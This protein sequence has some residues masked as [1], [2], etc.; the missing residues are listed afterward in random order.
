M[1]SVNFTVGCESTQWGQIVGVIG[2][3]CHWA[4]H[5]ATPLSTTASAFPEWT[6]SVVLPGFIVA[7]SEVEY[8]YVILANGTVVRWE[9]GDNRS[10]RAPEAGGSINVDGG[11]FSRERLNKPRRQRNGLKD[12]R[13]QVR[14]IPTESGYRLGDPPSLAVAAPPVALE[15]LQPL[16]RALVKV[17]G[18]QSS[19]RQRLQFIRSVI[20]PS[21]D[22]DGDTT[23][24]ADIGPIAGDAGSLAVIAAYLSF[25]STGQLRCE[26]DGGHH[27]PNRHAEAAQAIDAALT[28]A[29]AD[30]YSPFVARRIYPL[31]PSYAPQ[32]T[33][34]TPLTRIRDIAHR[35]DIP[36]DLKQEIKHTLQNKLH[37]CAGPEDLVTCARL[38]ERV[39]HGGYSDA[40]VHELRRFHAELKQFFN[41]EGLDDRLQHLIGVDGCQ[42]GAA[43]MLRVKQANAKPRDQLSALTDLR[44]TL[45]GQMGAAKADDER[46]ATR[47]ADI[48]LE[49]YAFPLLAALAGDAENIDYGCKDLAAHLVN[50]LAPVLALAFDNIGLSG[51]RPAEADA[52]AAEL[53]A[54]QLMGASRV[55]AL[56]ARAAVARAQRFAGAFASAVGDLFGPRVVAL[57]AAL[58]VESRA[59]AVF[60]ESEVRAN[61]AFQA[62]R[63]ADAA[64]SIARSVLGLPAWDPLCAGRRTGVPLYVENLEDVVFD[65]GAK[66]TIVIARNANGEEDIPSQVVAVILGR[67]MPHLSHLAL[68]AR[69][70]NVVFVCAEERGEFQ[71]VWDAPRPTVGLISVTVAD[72]LRQFEACKPPVKKAA[73]SSNTTTRSKVAIMGATEAATGGTKSTVTDVEMEPLPSSDSTDVGADV[74]STTGAEKKRIPPK[75]VL[76]E[77]ARMGKHVLTMKNT[78]LDRASAKATFV[79]RLSAVSRDSDGLFSVPSAVAI[80][81]AAFHAALKPHEEEYESLTLA[82]AAAANAETAADAA[83]VIRTFLETQLEVTGEIVDQLQAILRGTERVMVRSSANAEDLEQMSG[84]GLYDSIANVPL[85]DA[86]AVRKAVSSVWGSLWTRRAAASR[87]AAGVPH[88]AT[89]MA[90]LVQAM[91]TAHLS[92]VALSREPVSLAAGD[93]DAPIAVEVAVGM[94]ET[95]ASAANAGSPYRF[96]VGRETSSVETVAF[97]NFSDALV[98]AADGGTGLVAR[99]IDYSTE[100]MTNDEEFR[101]MVVG[102]IARVVRMLEGEFGGMQD[103]EGAVRVQEGKVEVFVVQARPQVAAGGRDV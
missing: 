20:A 80:S 1:A 86:S 49:G 67:P 101:E 93:R 65:D 5:E 40:F 102:R 63:V 72:G 43:R 70:A 73:V 82:Y 50:T 4:E 51:V 61:V 78:R 9:Q 58:G 59:A 54:L 83:D 84:A 23:P 19:W 15:D 71:K 13:T 18:E 44:K 103:V 76:K 33:V 64:A 69:Q 88:A 28:S 31:L 57:A 87:A 21:A 17:T 36:H 90:V 32:F 89:S 34:A 37:R 22:A 75:V 8:K 56:R 30:A 52:V 55:G 66:K 3:W 53:R 45:A 42:R 48:E 95:L 16:E 35:G 79:A 38:L 14:S 27:R 7:G 47:L 39:S 85:S 60:A 99:T 25:M 24:L 10:L 62:S 11:S 6:G 92:F 94:G 97:A 26:E 46:Q 29:S 98:P 41:A 96:R 74:G 12:A 81:H 77:V 2:S 100:R 68:R 91:A